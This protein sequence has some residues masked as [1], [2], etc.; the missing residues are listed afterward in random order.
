MGL[1]SPPATAC[2]LLRRS[3]SRM[4]TVILVSCLITG[5]PSQKTGCWTG[6]YHCPGGHLYLAKSG[7]LY[8]APIRL[9]RILLIMDSRLSA[10]QRN[11][12][13]HVGTEAANAA[14]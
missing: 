7:H 14:H 3:S 2:M 9:G 1:R 8:L 13:C 4:V 11:G 5:L 12:S 10:G 6:T